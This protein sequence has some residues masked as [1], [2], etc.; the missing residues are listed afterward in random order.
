MKSLPFSLHET[1]PKGL[2]KASSDRL[3]M[4]SLAHWSYMAQDWLEMRP[5]CH[6]ISRKANHVI[7][8]GKIRITLVEQGILSPVTEPT[9]W[10]NSIVYVSK[11]NRKIQM[12]IDPKDLN[13]AIK[14]PHY[15]TPTLEDVLSKLNGA[16]YFSILDLRSGYWNIKLDRESTLL[17]TFNTP[18]G[19]YMLNRLT[20]G[21]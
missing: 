4:A 13:K 8:C 19:R 18:F 12:C 16:K 10:V 20:F 1:L 3:V 2:G 14:R 15:Y 7:I 17:T 21:L 5:P 11:P 6:K 9:D